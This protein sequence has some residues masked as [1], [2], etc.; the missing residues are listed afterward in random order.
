M[1]AAAPDWDLAIDQVTRGPRNHFFGYIGHVQN[2]P[3]NA[4]G[5]FLVALRT[6]FQ[7]HMPS[8]AEAADVV[9]ID[10]QR[11][12]SVE[13]IEQTR[14][15][16][17]QQG[18]MFYW[19]PKAQETQ[20]LFNDRDPKTNHV[21]PVLYD[22][23]KRKRIREFRFPDTPF[24]N[25]G[26]AQQ[27]GYFAA[28]NYGRL[29]RLRPVTGYPQAFDWNPQTPAPAND[30]IFV[31]DIQSGK[32]RLL[33]SFAQLATHA[34]AQ[35]KSIDGQ[36]LFINHTLWSRDGKHLYFFLRADFDPKSERT[37]NIPC[38]IRPDGSGLTMHSIFIGGHP[39]WEFGSRIIGDVDGKQVLYDVVEKR[40]VEV[41]GDGAVFPNPGGDVALSPDG[42]W[43]V[44]GYRKGVAN[45]YIVFRRSDRTYRVTKG[46]PHPGKTSGELRV[47][48]SP[49]WNRTSNEIVFPAIADDGTRQIFRIR[50][51]V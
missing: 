46:F 19:N 35:V 15:W 40:V 47:D 50:I 28:I 26:V 33:V 39:E 7:D 41:I 3:W 24:G 42:K 32:K 38:S 25:G 51:R 30:G 45:H 1:Q 12:F 49:N 2:I 43:F 14:G 31:V 16:N 34:K 6:G 29:A 37:V 22:I 44:N 4:S 23:E 21:F 8:P 5:R 9:L 20:L 17:F 27:G 18:T 36:Q 11:N 48:A 10:T 13:A